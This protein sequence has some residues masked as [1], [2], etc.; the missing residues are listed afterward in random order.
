MAVKGDCRSCKPNGVQILLQAVQ[1]NKYKMW[2]ELGR[3]NRGVIL[4]ISIVQGVSNRRFIVIPQGIDQ[5]RWKELIRILSKVVHGGGSRRWTGV[6]KK[7][8]SSLMNGNWDKGTLTGN[9][10]DGKI[11]KI[12]GTRHD[13]NPRVDRSVF[14]KWNSAV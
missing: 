3:N 1:S 6:V 10:R 7:D 13:L 9:R 2:E 11:L 5:N 4:T 8:V 14:G 12:S